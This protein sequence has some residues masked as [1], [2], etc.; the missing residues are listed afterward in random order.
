MSKNWVSSSGFPSLPPPTYL[1]TNLV[2]LLD[3]KGLAAREAEHK[4]W[5]QESQANT[6]PIPIGMRAIDLEEELGIDLDDDE[7]N[8]SV[9]EEEEEE[10]TQG[11]I[12]SESAMEDHSDWLINRFGEDAPHLDESSIQLG[13]ISIDP[14]SSV[15]PDG[16]V[17]PNSNPYQSINPNASVDPDTYNP[18]NNYSINPNVSFDLNAF[19]LNASSNPNVSIDPSSNSS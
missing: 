13:D 12:D 8:D 7:G 4:K 9:E 5:L 16:S 15:S 17:D 18:I 10:D 19:D 11:T 14:Y 3:C 2:S 1:S 6:C